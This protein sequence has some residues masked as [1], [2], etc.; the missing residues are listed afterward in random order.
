M[1]TPPADDF[2]PAPLA[3]LS[4]PF[5]ADTDE[6][7]IVAEISSRPIGAF[8]GNR[9]LFTALVPQAEA[10]AVLKA[11]GGIG[12]GVECN[13]P[14]PCV[15]AEGAYRP[16][17]WIAGPVGSS[18]V[19]ETLVHTWDNHNKSVILPDSGFLMCYGLVPRVLNNGVICWDDPRRPVY[20][21]LRLVPL[22]EYSVATG[23]STARM[24]IQRD[25]LEDYLSLR[26]CA[27][28]V[29][30]F[31]ERFSRNDPDVE[32]LLAGGDGISFVLSGR[33][34]WLK[35]SQADWLGNQLSQVWG[36][37]LLLAPKRRP[38]S[39]EPEAQL[40]WPD[41]ESALKGKDRGAIGLGFEYAYVRDEVLVEYEEHDEFEVNPESGS[42]SYDG[43]WCVPCCRRYGRN[44]I[45]IEL[46]KIYEGAPFNIIKHFNKFAVQREVAERDRDVHGTRHIGNRARDV[47]YAFLKL[48]NWLAELSDALGL[49][50]AQQEIGQLVTADVNYSGWWTFK[51]L[52]PLGHVVPL[53]LS[54]VN[55]LGRCTELFK[56]LEN[57]QPGPLR[58]MLIQLGIQ[59]GEIADFRSLKLLGTLCQLAA[60]ATMNAFHLVS[61]RAHVCSQWNSS[62]ILAELRPLFAL[63]T[64]RTAE[65]HVPGTSTATKISEALQAFGIDRDEC[66]AGWGKALDEVYDRFTTS[67][68]DIAR[69][70]ERSSTG[71]A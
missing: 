51:A 22:S 67:L 35:R 42:V 66:R 39:D 41:R 3:H 17:F 48:T 34:L 57:L 21:V 44:H 4:H 37:S 14:H 60:I 26:G 9:L 69:L 43:W 19:F 71:G 2:W 6:D 1:P 13:G 58:Q 68:E 15:S 27:A 55:F 30:Y 25:Y 45:E 8:P 7:V 49:S 32:A 40:R 52:R 20:N 12:H 59:K 31:E 28:V 53:S 50:S 11:P 54:F 65:A 33:K 70:I 23:H 16:Y 56:L 61:D 5:L 38:I 10:S 46:G 24:T 63:N 36:C 47:V 64:L 62:V 29:T 18:K